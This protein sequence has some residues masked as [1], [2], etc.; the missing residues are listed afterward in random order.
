MTPQMMQLAQL[1]QR[2]LMMQQGTNQLGAFLRQLAMM[3]KS[4]GSSQ[5]M[6]NPKAGTKIAKAQEH[7]VSA[8]GDL[9]EQSPNSGGAIQNAMMDLIKPPLGPAAGG[10]GGGGGGPPQGP[11]TPAYPMG[12]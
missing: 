6:Q 10:G 9:N 3:I 2:L 7:L 5:F 11:Q 8:I 4:A 1:A 12:M